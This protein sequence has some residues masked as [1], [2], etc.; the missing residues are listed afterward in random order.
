MSDEKN[1][2]KGHEDPCFCGCGCMPPIK[3]GKEG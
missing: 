1:V 2:E 3:D